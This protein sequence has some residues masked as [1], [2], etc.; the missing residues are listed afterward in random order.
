MQI[1]LFH[2]TKEYTDLVSEQGRAL[3]DS[4]VHDVTLSFHAGEVLGILGPAGAGKRTLLAILAGCATPS[5]G[6]VRMDGRAVDPAEL[7]QI[8]RLAS[9]AADIEPSAEI[10]L[11]LLHEPTPA[12]TRAA[13]LQLM[14]PRPCAVVIATQS[15]PLAIALCDRVALFC[16]GYLVAQV[17]NAELAR[18]AGGSIAEIRVRSRVDSDWSDW[19]GGLEMTYPHPEETIMRGTVRDQTEVYGILARIRDMSIPLISVSITA[20]DLDILIADLCAGRQT[21]TPASAGRTVAN[22]WNKER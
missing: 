17:A 16:A 13:L 10:A 1:D 22:S 18:L 5:R 20:R 2:V 9:D 4:P 11:I 15:I 3:H 19:F 12:P 8:A 7:A 6:E 14:R 21:L